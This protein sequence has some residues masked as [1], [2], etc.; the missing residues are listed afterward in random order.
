MQWMALAGLCL[1]GAEAIAQE[2]KSREESPK[3]AQREE[4]PKKVH[5][6]ERPMED[7]AFLG[8]AVSP[9]PPSLRAQ[10]GIDPGTGLLVHHVEQESAAEGTIEQHDVLIRF[11]GQVLVN[12][13]QLT[14]L[15]R[16]AGVGSSVELTLMRA[17]REETVSV[18]LGERQVPAG[19]FRPRREA[20]GFP[21]FGGDDVPPGRIFP[22]HRHRDELRREMKERAEEAREKVHDLERELRKRKEDLQRAPE[23]GE[24]DAARHR[25]HRP[26]EAERQKPGRP[27]RPPTVRHSTW[28]EDGLVLNLIQTG[29]DKRL[30]VQKDGE[31][32]FEGPVNTE[33]QREKVPVEY[34]DELRKMESEVDGGDESESE[35]I[36]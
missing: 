36:L 5:R 11:N 26:D 20:F 19:R 4:S 14:V 10:L 6:E 2:E 1:G 31:T 17:G 16:N 34:R 29:K 32:V 13:D 23:G 22:G 3:K 30:T 8:V 15:V 12:Q 7:V 9:A 25:R 27:D 33:T 21:R 24:R 28:V 18:E 35:T